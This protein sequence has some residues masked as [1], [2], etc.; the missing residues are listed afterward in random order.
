MY[1]AELDPYCYPGTAVLINRLGI[2]EQAAL[3][4]FEA[5]VTAERASQP[6]PTGRLSY[7]HYRALHRHVFQDVYV[8]AGKIRT[9]RISKDG[10]TFCYPENIDRE[11]RRVFA[12]LVKQRHLRGLDAP[13]FAKKAAQFLAELNAIHPFREGNGRTQL[14]FLTILSER[15][16][17]PLRLERLNP[18]AMLDATINSFQGE[19]R[20]LAALIAELIR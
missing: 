7:A 16:G 20:R 13:A 10:S 9:V 4:A 18:A 5:E 6:L 2:R 8:W 12:D 11:M 19:E 17:H 14:S 1:R 3:D 15:A